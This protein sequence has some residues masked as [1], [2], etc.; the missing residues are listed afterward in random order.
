LLQP[1]LKTLDTITE[2]LCT[3]FGVAL[4]IVIML[5]CVDIFIRNLGFGSLPWMVEV[6]EYVMYAGTFLAGPW[7]LRQGSHVR[8]DLLLIALPRA[9]G[10]RLEQ[11]TD[12]LGLIV[13]LIML[14]YGS[15]VVLDAYRFKMIQFKSLAIPEWML[16]MPIVIGCLLLAIEFVLRMARVE[17]FVQ[18]HYNPADRPTI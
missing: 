2:F 13:S 9:A 8:V 18:D 15:V 3:L 10:R 11:F 17:G 5:I 7:V 14:Y 16:L 6:T 4:G 1:L 12:L